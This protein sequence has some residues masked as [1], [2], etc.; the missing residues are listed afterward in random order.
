[1]VG[2]SKVQRILVLAGTTEARQLCEQ[3]ANIPQLDVLASFAKPLE[4]SQQYPTPIRSGGF[5][6]LKGL[7]Q[8]IKDNGIDIIADATHPFA[9]RMTQN[10]LLASQSTRISYIRLER[11]EWNKSE[12][13]DCIQAA[14]LSQL[15]RLLPPGAT[16]FAP[17]GSG[18]YRSENLALLAEHQ[19]VKFVIRSI[20]FPTV[21]LPDNVFKVICDRPPFSRSSEK[22][23][24]RQIGADCLV[25][26]NS[27]G[28]IG[29][30]KVQAAQELGIQIF[31]LTRP[32]MPGLMTIYR[33]VG[34]AE[35]KIRE[36]LLPSADG[37]AT[38]RQC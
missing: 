36:L 24:L 32:Q 19:N 12:F 13:G 29:L 14:C 38:A 2:R 15:F 37:S 5:G 30:T 35:A 22:G 20:E 34:D 27:G 9:S 16:A 11:P 26:K 18:L 33:T 10:A 25:C 3:L 8:F 4:K 17:L 28:S 1:M 31:V 23:I 21:P 7:V 6:G